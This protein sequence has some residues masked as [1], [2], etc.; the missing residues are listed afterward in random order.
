MNDSLCYDN[1]NF[2]LHANLVFYFYCI[3]YLDLLNHKKYFRCHNNLSIER[4]T[5]VNNTYNRNVLEFYFP[6]KFSCFCESFHLELIFI[7]N[8]K[9]K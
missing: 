4:I 8:R 1:H 5:K 9:Q 3:E 2:N 7:N 6:L